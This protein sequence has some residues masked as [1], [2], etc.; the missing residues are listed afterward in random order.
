MSHTKRTNDAG[1]GAAVVADAVAAVACVLIAAGPF[2]TIAM[3]AGAGVED[4]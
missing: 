2:L 1:A 3:P 4:S